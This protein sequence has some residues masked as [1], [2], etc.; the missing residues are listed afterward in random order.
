MKATGRHRPG[1]APDLAPSQRPNQRL[2]QRP[3][4]R[5]ICRP[6]WPL[7]GARQLLGWAAAVGIALPA[8]AAPA[9]CGAQLGGPARQVAELG[10]LTVVFAPR[11][12]P[13]PV[14][15]HFALDI[16]VCAAPGSALPASLRVDA[17]MPAHRHGMN[18]KPTVQALGDGRFVAEGLMF[19][20]PG[21]WRFLFYPPSGAPLT[22]EITAP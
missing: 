16:A 22:G 11:P 13:V 19:H 4:Q 8:G 3:I 9:S 17:D 15:R 7:G 20:M 5:P 6:T 18:Y 14:G 1:A 2:N 10:T 12:W 21:R